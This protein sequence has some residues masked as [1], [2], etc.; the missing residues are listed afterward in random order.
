MYALLYQNAHTVIGSSHIRYERDE[1]KIDDE[2][3]PGPLF[4]IILGITQND[5]DQSTD[6]YYHQYTPG[7]FIYACIIVSKRTH[8]HW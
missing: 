1:R 7:L 3:H 2:F 8:R 4:P 6:S 5:F